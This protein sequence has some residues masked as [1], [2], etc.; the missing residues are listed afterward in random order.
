MSTGAIASPHRTRPID[1]AVRRTLAAELP[2]PLRRVYGRVLEHTL[3]EGVPVDADALA[4]VL[5]VMDERFDDPLCF[6]PER[7]EELIWF[8]IA[9]F[10]EANE[11]SRPTRCVEALF[12]VVVI[13]LSDPALGAVAQDRKGCFAVLR[14]LSTTV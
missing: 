12:A 1:R 11:L 13:G 3:R 2:V 10:C 9:A 5:S 14:Q 6:E 7:I 4:V 8:A